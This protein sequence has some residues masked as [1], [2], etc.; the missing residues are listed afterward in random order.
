M[1]NASETVNICVCLYV[2]PCT[3]MG[4]DKPHMRPLRHKGGNICIE[5]SLCPSLMEIRSSSLSPC[6]L[7]MPATKT[8]IDHYVSAEWE[9]QETSGRNWNGGRDTLI[10]LRTSD[11]HS[12]RICSFREAHTDTHTHTPTQTGNAYIH[13]KRLN[14]HTYKSGG[15]ICTVQNMH[16]WLTALDLNVYTKAD[17]HT[18][19]HPDTYF[20]LQ[21]PWWS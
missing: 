20:G 3:C 12:D 16:A 21:S 15:H 5:G 1:Y 19:T 6:S 2:C 13:L 9:G 10:Q 4:V 18:R 17:T 14:I 7:V 8:Q 11:T